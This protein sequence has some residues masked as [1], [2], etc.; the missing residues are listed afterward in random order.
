[1]IAMMNDRANDRAS[2][3]AF[4]GIAESPR[5]NIGFSMRLL[6]AAA[7]ANETRQ[8]SPVGLLVLW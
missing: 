2:R 5:T 4:F 3:E 7:R 8:K 6:M 1:M